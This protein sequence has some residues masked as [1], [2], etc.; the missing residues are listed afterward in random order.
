MI[1]VVIFGSRV[2]FWGM[3]N[4]TVSFKW[5]KE[6]TGRNYL[7]CLASKVKHCCKLI[8]TIIINYKLNC[9]L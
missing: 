6:Q 2:W 9:S 4:L 7:S 5:G 1:R 8:M 3:A